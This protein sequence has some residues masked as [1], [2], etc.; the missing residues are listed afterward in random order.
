[1]RGHDALY[2]LLGREVR[3]DALDVEALR[4]QLLDRTGELLRPPGRDRQP[5]ALRAQLVG[6]RE[7]DPAGGSGH[8]GGAVGHEVLSVGNAVSNQ[9]C[10]RP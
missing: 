5:V 2:V 6:D 3:R 4:A 9:G 8:E 7:A 10:A 1:V